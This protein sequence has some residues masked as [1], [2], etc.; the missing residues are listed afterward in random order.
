MAARSTTHANAV[1][2]LA[3]QSGGRELETSLVPNYTAPNID[4]SGGTKSTPGDGYTYHVYPH[5][6]WTSQPEFTFEVEGTSGAPVVDP[7]IHVMCTASGGGGG[8]GG[9]CGCGCGCRC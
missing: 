7:T 6:N 8:G 3:S 1:S 5:S 9:G 2:Q 4:A